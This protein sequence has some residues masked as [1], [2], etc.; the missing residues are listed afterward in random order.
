[1]ETDIRHLINF[2]KV[3]TLLEGFNKSTGFLTAILDLEG[4]VLSKSGWRQMCTEFHR[5]NPETSKKCTISDTELANKM[6]VGEK[7]HFYKCLNG[8]IDVAVPIIIRGEHV[9]NLFSGQ[10]FFEEPDVT[11]F[12]KQ[13]EKYGFDEE[14]YLTA[15]KDVP[16]VS[17]EK[18]K[19]A[20]D[21][22]LNMTRMI[23]DITFQKLEQI[24]LNKK[25]RESEERYRLLAENM[26]DVVWR[27]DAETRQILYVSPNVEKFRGFTSAEIMAKPLADAIV[28]EQRQVF[29]ALIV[30]HVADFNNGLLTESD[31]FTDEVLQLCKDGST[32][33]TEV[34]TNYSRDK[35]SGHVMLQGTARDITKRRQAEEKIREKDLQFRK[36]SANLPDL[37]YQF[38]RKPDGSYCVPV[39]SAGIKNIFGCSPEDV[40]DDF[41]PISRVIFPEDSERVIH[42]IEYSAKHLS[43]FSCEFRVQIP[44]KPIQWILS[45][46]T[47]EQLPDGSITWYGFNADITER[48]HAEQALMAKMDELERFHRLTVDRE[49]TMIELKKEVNDLLNKLGQGNKYSI[50]E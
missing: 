46:S 27:F 8:L 15:L 45:R 49:L 31:F 41:A 13:A 11:F 5:I 1:M 34:V 43:Y 7:Y 30:N 26:K 48:K 9:A 24:E 18:V 4:N 50:H 3:D 16:V 19:T 25:I 28:P 17:E 40:I 22:L 2:E 44:G 38:T 35:K 42:E 29:D 14:K 47:P 39:S 21:F 6:G 10:F 36:L 33:W 12:K 23:S 37:I 20:M 32:I